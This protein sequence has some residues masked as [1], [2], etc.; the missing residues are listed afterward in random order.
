MSGSTGRV[1]VEHGRDPKV[2]ARPLRTAGSALALATSVLALSTGLV[3][4]PSQAATSH[5]RTSPAHAAA[6]PMPQLVRQNGHWALMVDGAPYF[7]LGAQVNNSSAWPSMLPKVWPAIT[8]LSANTVEVPIAWEQIEPVEGRFD[9]SFLDTLLT[10]AREHHVHLVLLWFGA[11]KN[12]GPSYAPAW[13]KL[14]NKRFPRVIDSKGET[15]YSLSPFYASTLNADRTAFTAFM[16]HLKAADPQRT[17]LMV[18]VENE[19]GIY[20]PVRDYAPAAQKL[21]DG[22]VPE[23]IVKATGK[24][25]G[26]WTEVFGKDADEY[27]YAW[28]VSHYVDQVAA[29]GKAE[30]PLPYY[31]NAALRDAFKYQDPHSFASGGPT[32][33]VLDIWKATVK[34]IDVIGPDIYMHDYP[35]YMKTLEQYQRPDNALF[36]PETANTADTP[37]Y[38]FEVIGRGGIGFSPFGMDYTGYVNFPLGAA[39]MDEESVEAFARNYRLFQPVMRELAALNLQGKVWGAAEPTDLHQQ[40]IS[41]GA[42]Q[43]DVSYG[44]PQF[45]SDPAKGNP[46]P[47]GGVV[48]AELAPDT[49]EVLGYHVRVEFHPTD[50]ALKNWIYAKVEEGHY[51]AKGVWVFDR[52]WN[53]DQTDYGL[54]LTSEP[55]ILRVHLGRY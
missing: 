29:A 10:Q 20:G 34:S 9:F 4:T 35:S 39:K 42:W 48:V 11:Y 36:V 37:R 26:T 2:S 23:A 54:N 27:F 51:D 6:A 5:H 30:Y 12:T 53:G 22:P 33:D 47:A 55:Q 46:V 15:S 41:V 25:P 21:F 18:Q 3:P 8:R 43:V 45:G 32:W 1:S 13:V 44:R 38:L 31:V 50:K 19:T 40:T 28:G 14:D 16:R 17:T 7:M 52:I 49:Y 24:T